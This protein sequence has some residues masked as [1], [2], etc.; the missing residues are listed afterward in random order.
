MKFGENLKIIR[1]SKKISQEELA[2]KLGV[3]RQSISKWETGENYPTM[4]NIICLCDIFKCKMND[5]VH[6]KFLDINFFDEEI[7][8][9]VAKLNKEEQ[10]KV[11]ILSNILSLIGKIASIVLKVGIAFIILFMLI[12]PILIKT[13]D[14]ENNKI[15]S[16][17]K[18]LTIN[19]IDKGI[20]IS[21]KNHKNIIIASLNNKDINLIKKNYERKN[22]TFLITFIE[23]SLTS[24]LAL[25]VLLIFFF[26]HLEKLFN[27]IKEGETPF[28]LDNV[29]HIKKMTYFM[30]ASIIVSSFGQ[31]FLNIALK[32]DDNIIEM[33]LFNVVEIIFLYVMTYIFEY[34]YHIQKDSNGILYEDEK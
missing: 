17:N 28:T 3:S 29:S 7:K 26:N 9:K 16:N 6:E 30:I 1:K 13:I 5:L 27:N 25:L 2:E 4:T 19:E 20:T 31:I 15:V 23:L 8:M 24:I 18:N 14:V 21:Y 11:K 10:K 32:I 22:K 34:G 33:N 12:I